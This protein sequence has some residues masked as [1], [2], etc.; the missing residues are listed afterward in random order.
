MLDSAIKNVVHIVP[1]MNKIRT[2]L[3][4]FKLYSKDVQHSG[5]MRE[6]LVDMLVALIKL[7]AAVTRALTKSKI[8]GQ[9]GHLS[10]CHR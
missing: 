8:F 6:A 10:T 2:Q 1:L 4:L 5:E 3:A 9:L 7:W